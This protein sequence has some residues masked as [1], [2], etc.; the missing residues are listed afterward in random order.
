MVTACGNK[1]LIASFIR[2]GIYETQNG[3]QVTIGDIETSNR[4]VFNDLWE[5]EKRM[6][7]ILL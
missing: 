5:N 7:T 4:I 3:I 1:Y 2:V 6:D